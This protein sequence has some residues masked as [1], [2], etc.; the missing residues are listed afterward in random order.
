MYLLSSVHTGPGVHT[1]VCSV[2]TPRMFVWRVERPKRDADHSPACNVDVH[3][4][5]SFTSTRPCAFMACTETSVVFWRLVFILLHG[6]KHIQPHSSVTSSTFRITSFM[7]F[8]DAGT[9]YDEF[10]PKATFT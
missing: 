3:I 10:D 5:W 9:R 7:D 8:R 2:G 6:P 1:R 4:E